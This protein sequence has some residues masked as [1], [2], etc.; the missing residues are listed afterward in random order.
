MSFLKSFWWVIGLIIIALIAGFV[1]LFRSPQQAQAT[2]QAFSQLSST[3]KPMSSN[4]SGSLATTSNPSG[5][6]STGSNQ[7]RLSSKPV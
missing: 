3:I 7:P 5:A 2:T 6:S 4:P 1:F